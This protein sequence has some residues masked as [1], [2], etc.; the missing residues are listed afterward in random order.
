VEKVLLGN[1]EF[2]FN[3]YLMHDR[4]LPGRSAETDETGL[5][6]EANGLLK[7]TGFGK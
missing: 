6:P 2:P 4:D 1:P 3:Q 7:D 5:Q